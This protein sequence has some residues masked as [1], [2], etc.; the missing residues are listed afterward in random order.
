MPY[1]FTQVATIPQ[2]SAFGPWLPM[3]SFVAQGFING[4]IGPYNNAA[5]WTC[6]LNQLDTGGWS[7][8]GIADTLATESAAAAV[9]HVDGYG[10]WNTEERGAIYKELSTGG[11][12]R[13]FDGWARGTG[14]GMARRGSEYLACSN[15]DIGTFNRQ[16][17]MA[18]DG[19]GFSDVATFEEEF[20]ATGLYASPSG[21]EWYIP[22]C[23]M[24]PSGS[25][26]Q[27]QPQ[28][29]V[30][31]A[32]YTIRVRAVVQAEPGYLWRGCFL[33]DG[34]FIVSHRNGGTV[35]AYTEGSDV[36]SQVWVS[37][38]TRIDR[39]EPLFGKIWYPCNN[40]TLYTSDLAATT[41]TLEW[42]HPTGLGL[43]SI[44]QHPGSNYITVWA[45]S[46]DDYSEAWI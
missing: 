13:V 1:T 44:G 19:S 18:W 36:L 8:A 9:R 5:I 35:Y 26:S 21:A 2:G 16:H 4:A 42:S 24:S 29:W 28:L 40:G 23:R 14:L 30:L 34:R 32:D 33:P 7:Q 11:I 25:I 39:I 41:W 37:G 43:R 27:G 31:R 6:A 17:L 46:G 38:S 22:G 45:N 15:E 10:L 20:F 12:I 3:G